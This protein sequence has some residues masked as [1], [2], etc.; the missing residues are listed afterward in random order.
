MITF[1]LIMEIDFVTVR[2]KIEKQIDL[3][4]GQISTD[5]ISINY[6]SILFFVTNIQ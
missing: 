6:I 3:N 2:N 5:Y 1:N 4:N